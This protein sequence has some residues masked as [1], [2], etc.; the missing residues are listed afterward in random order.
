MNQ[1]SLVAHASPDLRDS[2]LT[3][4]IRNQIINCGEI[5]AVGSR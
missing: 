5:K 3:H 4:Q 1:D 2:I